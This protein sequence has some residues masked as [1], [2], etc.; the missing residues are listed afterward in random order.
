MSV[1]DTIDAILDE[2]DRQANPFTPHPRAFRRG[3][4]AIVAAEHQP[5]KAGKLMAELQAR[6]VQEI[7]AD[8]SV[9]RETAQRED[10]QA[11]D[12]SD[13]AAHARVTAAN[14]HGAIDRDRLRVATSPAEISLF[15]RDAIAHSPDV[16]RREWP[17]AEAKLK[18]MSRRED[19]AHVLPTGGTAFNLLCRLQV[20]MRALSQRVPDCAAL[21]EQASARAKKLRMQ[22]LEAARVVGLDG[23]VEASLRRAAVPEPPPEP[24]VVLGGFFDRFGKR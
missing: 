22:A 19:R 18:E 20:E 3:Q 21:S 2:L 13:A 6:I 15:M 1:I 14:G 9:R 10:A 24:R 16:A 4:A 11:A 17:F 5:G 12:A 8:F 7:V 23:L